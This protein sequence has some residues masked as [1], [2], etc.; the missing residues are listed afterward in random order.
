MGKQIEIVHGLRGDE[1]L[2][3]NPSDLLSEGQAI[4]EQ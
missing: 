4:K 2:V 1:A 3:T